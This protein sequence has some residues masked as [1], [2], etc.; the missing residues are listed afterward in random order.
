MA[1][2]VCTGSGSNCCKFCTFTPDLGSENEGSRELSKLY[3]KV[4]GEISMEEYDKEVGPLN[5]YNYIPEAYTK[6]YKEV[7][8]K[9]VIK[10]I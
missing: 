8:R 2:G 6:S 9:E 1:E 4:M 7:L 5:K 10:L 3:F